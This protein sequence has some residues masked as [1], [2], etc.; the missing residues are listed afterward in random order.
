MSRGVQ[1]SRTVR[2]GHNSVS[3]KQAIAPPPLSAA[4]SNTK[5]KVRSETP[6][7]VDELQAVRGLYE[8]HQVEPDDHEQHNEQK[9]PRLQSHEQR[10]A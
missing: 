3:I 9:P 6:T 5:H 8:P 1:K 4:L 7:Y 10:Q 2:G